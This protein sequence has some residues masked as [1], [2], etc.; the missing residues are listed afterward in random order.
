MRSGSCSD[1]APAD[2]EEVEVWNNPATFLALVFGLTA[3][4][5]LE[6][7]SLVDGLLVSE[8]AE[9]AAA[10]EYM[11]GGGCRLV[12]TLRRT[13]MRK[14]KTTRVVRRPAIIPISR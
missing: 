3:L 1:P 11:G 5:S 2:W 9:A 14:A 7:V 4:L 6:G 13:T 12:C 10:S 8:A